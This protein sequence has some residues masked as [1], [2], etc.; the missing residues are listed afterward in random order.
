[1]L[2]QHPILQIEMNELFLIKRCY[3]FHLHQYLNFDILSILSILAILP[4]LLSTLF[5]G[6]EMVIATPG[7]LLD[8]LERRYAVLNQCNYVV[9]DEAD[10]MIEMGFEQQVMGVLDAMPSTN[11]KPENE[12]VELE[13]NRVYRTTYMFSATMPSAVERLARKY[14]RRPVTVVIGETAWKFTSF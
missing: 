1:M 12:D 7:R 13:K 8:C 3:L 6:C 10:K 5:P 9:L 4:I 14:L 11:L 2:R